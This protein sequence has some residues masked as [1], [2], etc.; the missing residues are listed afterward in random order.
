[1][2]DIFSP[3]HHPIDETEHGR[4]LKWDIRFVKLA[5]FW[6]LECSKDPST[7]CGA[8]IVRE[9]NRDISKGYN[10]LPARIKDYAERLNTREVKY[11]L[12]LHAEENAILWAR[13][14]LFGCTIYT[15]P[16][17]SCAHCAALLAQKGIARVVSIPPTQYIM[18]RWGGDIALAQEVFHEANIALRLL[19]QELV[20]VDNWRAIC[21]DVPL[22]T[23]TEGGSS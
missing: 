1:M 3:N 12:T 10:G 11:R 16:F 14:P 9:V 6:A 8:V 7:K 13:E 22:P 18:D 2:T 23:E 4:Q 15:W 21:N 17:Q 20:G 19:N 5:K